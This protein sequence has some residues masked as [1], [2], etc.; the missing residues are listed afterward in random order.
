MSEGAQISNFRDETALFVKD[1]G[2]RSLHGKKLLIVTVVRI[3]FLI[4]ACVVDI[5][6]LGIKPVYH[7]SSNHVLADFSAG[8][9]N[10]SDL[11]TF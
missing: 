3:G 8:I 10:K 5:I 1:L 2:I 4:F 7:T 9:L 11:L 6:E